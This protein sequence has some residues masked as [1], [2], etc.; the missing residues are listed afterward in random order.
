M[1]KLN[2]AT[3]L[4]LSTVL[5]TAAQAVPL[6]GTAADYGVA[7]PVSADGRTVTVKPG[8]KYLNVTNGETVNISIGG[9][10][11]G[12]NVN[13]FPNQTVFD[14]SKIA[15]QDVAA[16]GVKVYVATNPTY[17]GN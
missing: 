5:A 13:A 1:L 9:K 3:I 12:W 16:D 6:Q 11:F 8:S 14:L 7:V 4:I 2:R 15:P 10:T 17:F